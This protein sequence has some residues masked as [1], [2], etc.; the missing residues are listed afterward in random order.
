MRTLEDG[1][2]PHSEVQ[3]ALVAAIEAILAGRNAILA[4]ASGAGYAVGPKPLFEVKPRSFCVGDHCEELEGADS[5]LAHVS[6]VVN[7]REGVKYYLYFSC[8][9][10]QYSR[11]NYCADIK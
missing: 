10:F 4:A 8:I 5:A 6:I 7:S 11:R 2:C 9:I 3:F 1:S